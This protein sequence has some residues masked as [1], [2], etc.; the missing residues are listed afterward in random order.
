MLFV[1]DGVFKFSQVAASCVQ[2]TESVKIARRGLGIE[3]AIKTTFA[4]NLNS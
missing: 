2:P 4:L 3:T 1:V